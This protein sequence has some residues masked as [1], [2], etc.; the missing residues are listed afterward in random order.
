MSHDNYGISHYMYLHICTFNRFE[1]QIKDP[2]NHDRDNGTGQH[3]IDHMMV[4]IV[5]VFGW[6]DDDNNGTGITMVSMMVIMV[7]QFDWSDDVDMELAFDW[8]DD[9]DSNIWYWHLI[10]QMMVA[11]VMAFHQSGDG[12]NGNGISLVR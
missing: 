1:Q 7:Q 2:Q 5:L 6:S 12:D 9:G 8:S 10:G 4:I 3:L 11:M